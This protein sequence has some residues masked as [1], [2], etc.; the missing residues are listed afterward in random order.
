ML[1]TTATSAENALPSRK[2]W[3]EKYE[4]GSNDHTSFGATCGPRRGG[5]TDAVPLP[6]PPDE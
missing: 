5:S 3:S 2:S 6:P 4:S 1:H